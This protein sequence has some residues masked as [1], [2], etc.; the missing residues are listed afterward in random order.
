MLAS[1]CLGT[2]CHAVRRPTN[3]GAP[4]P[5]DVVSPEAR[6]L[7]SAWKNLGAGS[8]RRCAWETME[9]L[10]QLGRGPA[11]DGTPQFSRRAEACHRTLRAGG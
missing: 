9:M 5:P 10:G 6:A 8:S 1:A 7:A 3:S 11:E 2:L 4:R